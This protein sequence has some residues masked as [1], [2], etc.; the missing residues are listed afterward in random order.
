M[1]NTELVQVKNIMDYKEE[2]NKVKKLTKDKYTVAEA[3]EYFGCTKS[4]IKGYH[5]NYRDIFEGKVTVEGDTGRQ[6]T[7]I[8]KDG[9]Y[10][11]AILLNKRSRV[12]QK[13]FDNVLA[14]IEGQKQLSID[15]AAATTATEEEKQ[16][17]DINNDKEMK[18]K[19]KKENV[20]TFED[21]KKKKSKNDDAIECLKF[22]L[23]EFGP[24]IEKVK[25]SKKEVEKELPK[26]LKRIFDEIDKELSKSLNK[27]NNDL[28]DCKCPEC[29]EQELLECCHE[30]DMQKLLAESTLDMEVILTERYMKKCEILGVDRLEAAIMIQSSIVDGEVN[31]D[32]KIL[33]YL[34]NEK[35]LEIEKKTSVLKL[36][37]ELLAEEKCESIEEAFTLFAQEM[38]YVTGE[39]LER[40]LK[41]KNY[42]KLLRRVVANNEFDYALNVIREYLAQ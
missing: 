30:A 34:V 7:I 1:K 32:S 20:I 29:L 19:S 13:L 12:A 18:V 4:Q 5:T 15:E 26:E 8:N 10:L 37:I 11:M 31:I 41:D 22:E 42:D 40:Y 3:A 16:T 33:D 6:K 24:K 17:S 21:L 36:S 35:T 38:R 9:M 27:T 2:L 39:R 28:R 14:L 25:M 23:T